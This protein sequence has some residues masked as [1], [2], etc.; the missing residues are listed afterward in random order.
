MTYDDSL[1]PGERVVVEQARKGYTATTYRVY[2]DANG[3]QIKKEVLCKSSYAAAGAVVRV[4]P[5]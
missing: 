1:L 2:Y 4:G 3:T 5:S